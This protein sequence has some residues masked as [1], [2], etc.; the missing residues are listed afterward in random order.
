MRNV[1]LWLKRLVTGR[2]KGTVA[3]TFILSLPILMLIVSIMGQRCGANPA[4]V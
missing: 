3:V 2:D 4:M 1:L